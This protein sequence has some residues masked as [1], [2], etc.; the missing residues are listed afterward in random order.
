MRYCATTDASR[1]AGTS[2]SRT[3]RPGSEE[4]VAPKTSN[5]G[6]LKKDDSFMKITQDA[7]A[8][9]GSTCVCPWLVSAAAASERAVSTLN[10]ERPDTVSAYEPAGSPSTVI[11]TVTPCSTA[12]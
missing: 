3:R 5:A 9:M 7:D 11:A 8:S 10:G 4:N 12:G 2:V 1:P 6:M